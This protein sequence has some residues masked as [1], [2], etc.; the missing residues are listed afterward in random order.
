VPEEVL[1]ERRAKMESSETPWQPVD[2][3]RPV[4]QALRAYAAM[5]QSAD[6]GAVRDLSRLDRQS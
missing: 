4:S 2:R 1:A 6:K 3:Q 5:A